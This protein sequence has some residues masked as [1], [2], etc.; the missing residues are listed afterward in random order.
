MF[1]PM[2]AGKVVDPEA[3]VYPL[4]ASPKLDGI[5][6]VILEGRPYSR[7]LKPIQ[8]EVIHEML[9]GL[10]AM[11]GELI[12]GASTG[13]DVYNR[14]NSGVM[15]RDGAPEFTFW[16]FDVLLRQS[17][18]FNQRLELAQSWARASGKFVQ[19]V[20][21]KLIRS[22]E[23]LL[24]YEGALLEAGYEGAMVRSLDGP[25]KH[26]RSTEREG[27]LLKLKRHEDSEAEVL[28]FVEKMHNE[29]TQTRDELGRAKRSSK[30]ETAIQELNSKSAR[31]S[32][33]K[34]ATKSGPDET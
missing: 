14:T 25:Y 12:V 22:P 1:K 20:P 19:A 6:C 10:P 30:L 5:R 9:S 34:F 33:M 2:L 8:N 29:N 21:H 13:N 32:R 17:L 7:N 28:G 16:V 24:A 31:A 26:G 11:D 4:L 18:P 3:L 27:F 15:S 23:G